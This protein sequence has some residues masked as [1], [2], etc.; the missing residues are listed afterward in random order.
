MGSFTDKL[1][2]LFNRGSG[3]VKQATGEAVGNDKL[4]AKGAAQEVKGNVQEAVEWK[5]LVRFPSLRTSFHVS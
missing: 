4:R 2:G 5:G 3:K 1:K